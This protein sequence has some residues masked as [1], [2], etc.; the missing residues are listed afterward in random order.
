M[1]NTIKSTFRFHYQSLINENKDNPKNMWRT[2]NKVLDKAPNSTLIMQIRDG[3][4]RVSNSKKIPNDLNSQFVNVGPRLASRIE[5]KS[6][7]SS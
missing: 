7:S 1:T 5:V 3:R 6:L 4:K 2:I